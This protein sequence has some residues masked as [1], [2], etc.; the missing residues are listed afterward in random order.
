MKN[1]H[2]DTKTLQFTNFYAKKTVLLIFGRQIQNQFFCNGTFNP[3]MYIG[4]PE[5]SFCQKLEEKY[6]KIRMVKI[7]GAPPKK[8]R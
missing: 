5:R 1:Q 3:R 6:V 8:G 4:E 2:I 7:C